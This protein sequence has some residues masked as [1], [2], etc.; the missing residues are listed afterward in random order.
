ML[1]RI[2][3]QP[4]HTECA[5]WPCRSGLVRGRLT[6]QSSL[7]HT[8]RIRICPPAR[9]YRRRRMGQFKPSGAPGPVCHTRRDIIGSARAEFAVGLHGT[10]TNDSAIRIRVTKPAISYHL[11]SYTQQCWT[12]IAPGKPTQNKLVENLYGRMRDELLN[13]T[14]FFGLDHAR[15]RLAARAKGYN[16]K[17]LSG[18]CGAI[19]YRRMTWCLPHFER[20]DSGRDYGHR[21]MKVQSASLDSRKQCW[22]PTNL[23]YAP[24]DEGLQISRVKTTREKVYDIHSTLRNYRAPPSSGQSGRY[25]RSNCKIFFHS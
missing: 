20:R 15:Q 13:E 5:Y 23:R 12:Y 14:L 18:T 11:G 25:R 1:R 9:R 21:W 10:S 4:G 17:G 19:Y 16:T 3:P 6:T 8:G 7:R 24:L 22:F 2:G